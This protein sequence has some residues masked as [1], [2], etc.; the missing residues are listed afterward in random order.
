[1]SSK[2]CQDDFDKLK[3]KYPRFE[4]SYESMLHKKVPENYDIV[5][6][7][8]AGKKYIA[9]FSFLNENNKLF[10]L[11]LNK[12]KQIINASCYPAAFDDS[13]ALGTLFYGTLLSEI[14]V[15]VIEDIHYYKGIHVSRLHMNAKLT[16]ICNLLSSDIRAKN[17]DKLSFSLPL[18]WEFKGVHGIPSDIS[19]KSGY[20]IH[21]TQ[22]RS[23]T[24]IVP[25]L[26]E[27]TRRDLSAGERKKIDTPIYI[28]VKC[29]YKKPQYRQPSVFKVKA[30]IQSDIY[31]LY[32]YGKNNAMV[33]YNSAYIRNYQVSVFMNDIFRRVKENRNLDY[34]EESDDEEDFQN[35]NEDKYVDLNKEVLM[36]CTFSEK[37]KRW[38]PIRL[39]R[40]QRVV[41]INQLNQF[42]QKRY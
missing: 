2:M 16:Y 39:V 15:F 27:H 41:H 8:P 12:E 21:H 26:N 1:M 6:G 17:T 10:L 3:G 38:E 9:W 32:A 28:P 37:F 18:M 35:I 25:F 11:E 22:Y 29:D 7:I 19:S 13:V 4:L 34:I 20:Q 33:Y 40:G 24:K 31:R 5:M 23:R 14:N 36:E 30:D 42:E